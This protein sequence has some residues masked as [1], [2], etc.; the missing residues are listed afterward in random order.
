MLRDASMTVPRGAVVGLLGPS[1]CGKTT[2]MRA[3]V[4]AQAIASGSVTVLDRPA[5]DRSLRGRIGDV[6]QRLSVCP[7][8]SVRDNVSYFAALSGV[9]WAP[10]PT[11]SARC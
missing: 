3:I 7:D 9:A 6:T 2:L 10:C 5:G 11:R 8:L 4:G 1:G